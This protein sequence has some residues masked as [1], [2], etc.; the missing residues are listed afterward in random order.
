MWGRNI[1]ESIT[2]D[3]MERPGSRTWTLIISV[4]PI[5]VKIKVG[6][7]FE[8]Q[9]NGMANRGSIKENNFYVDTKSPITRAP[10]SS[11]VFPRVPQE[12]VLE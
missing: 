5:I 10:Q 3:N 2:K 7:E 4:G 6:E 12:G 8:C 9:I 11:L 1:E